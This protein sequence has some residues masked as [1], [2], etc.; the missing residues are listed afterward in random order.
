M[1]R[2]SSNVLTVTQ[3]QTYICQTPTEVGAD[4]G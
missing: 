3:R 1:T 4:D 2:A